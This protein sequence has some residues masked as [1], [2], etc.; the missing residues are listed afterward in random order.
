MGSN[1]RFVLVECDGVGV[2]VQGTAFSVGLVFSDARRH[3]ERTAWL[4]G[5]E[6][7]LV[8]FDPAEPWDIAEV[9]HA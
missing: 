4:L 9:D 8:G 2:A 7:G 6:G 1:R 3:G 5:V